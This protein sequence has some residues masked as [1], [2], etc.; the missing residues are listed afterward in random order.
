MAASTT[1]GWYCVSIAGFLARNRMMTHLI[2]RCRG[3]D[4]YAGEV[5]ISTDMTMKEEVEKIVSFWE[6]GSGD[7][8]NRAVLYMYIT[9]SPR[10]RIASKKF[11]SRF[12]YSRRLPCP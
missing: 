10:M 1:A 3:R 5:H 2:I 9:C 4:H 6:Q 11:W 7:A 12:W 8:K